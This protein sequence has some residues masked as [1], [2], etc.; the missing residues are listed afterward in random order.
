[1]APPADWGQLVADVKERL[2]RSPGEKR[3]DGVG[4]PAAPEPAETTEPLLHLCARGGPG[5]SSTGPP[6]LTTSA[7]SR[8]FGGGAIELGAGPNTLMSSLRLDPQGKEW[9]R[10]CAYIKSGLPQ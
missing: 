5:L 3:A 6:E 10:A 1:M 7:A 9:Q 8:T 2:L 4:S